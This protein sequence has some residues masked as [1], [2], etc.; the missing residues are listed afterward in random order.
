MICRRNPSTRS[1]PSPV[2]TCIQANLRHGKTASASFAQIMMELDIDVALVQKPYAFFDKLIPGVPIVADVPEGFEALHRLDTEH[3]YGAALLTKKKLRATLCRDA[4]NNHVACATIPMGPA[5]VTFASVYI[6]PTAA[7]IE[8]VLSAPLQA[9]DRL[10][11]SVLGIDANARNPLWGSCRADAKGRELENLLL[12]S[13][14]VLANAALDDLSFRPSGTSFI[15]VTLHGCDVELLGWKYLDMPSL[16]DHPL[17][18]FQCRTAQIAARLNPT[19]QER[20]STFRSVKLPPPPA[21][22]RL[23]FSRQIEQA[24]EAHPP[25]LADAEEIDEA[26][27]IMT[28]AVQSAAI[29]SKLTNSSRHVPEQSKKMPWWNED[30]LDLRNRMWRASATWNLRKTEENRLRHIGLRSDYRRAIRAA[31]S[32]AFKQF[33]TEIG[34]DLPA[35]IKAIKLAHG[36][37]AALPARI[38]VGGEKIADQI[39]ILKACAAHFFPAD[40]PGT[41]ENRAIAAKAKE[42]LASANGG[43]PPVL[44]GEVGNA[45]ASL[46]TSSAPGPD[47]VSTALIQ[48]GPPGLVVRMGNIYD[49]CLKTGYFPKAWRH[50]RVS[51]IPKPGKP[52]YSSLSSFR[53]ISVVNAFSKGL[54]KIILTR[55]QWLAEEGN[56]FSDHQHGFRPG[57]STESAAHDLVHFIE[58][59]K[60]DNKT[61]AVAFLDIK[62]AFDSAWRPAII[63]ALANKGCPGYLLKIVDAFLAARTATISSSGHHL[64]TKIGTGCPQGSVLSPFLWNVLI[65]EVLR[66]RLHFPFKLVAYA[67]DLTAAVAHRD[68][69]VAAARLQLICRAIMKWAAGVKLAINAAKTTF[70]LFSRR[71]WRKIE[72]IR[73]VLAGIA[74]CPSKLASFL[75][76]TLDWRLSWRPHIERKTLA[77]KQ[78]GMMVKRHI[79]RNWG[80]TAQRIRTVYQA[81]VEPT[82]VYC[83]SVWSAAVDHTPS[84]IHLRRIQRAFGLYISRAFSSTSTEAVLNLAGFLPVDLRIK[85]LSARRYL[86]MANA[87][88]F[89]PRTVSSI[90]TLLAGLEKT[91]RADAAFHSSAAPPWTDA[92]ARPVFLPRDVPVPMFST[93]N[94]SARVYTDGSVTGGRA[95]Y[96]VVICDDRGIFATCKGRLDDHCSVLQAEGAAIREALSFLATAGGR[97][98]SVDILTDSRAAIA[99]CCTS[100]KVSPLFDDI[101]HRINESQRSI[102]FYWLAGH[103]GHPGNELADSLAKEGAKTLSSRT[104]R[105]ERPHSMLKGELRSR[106]ANMWDQEWR[107]CS[108]GAVTRLFLP[109]TTIPP[110]LVSFNISRPLAQLLTGHSYLRAHLFR[111]GLAD[112]AVCPCGAEDETVPHLIFSCPSHSAERAT[113]VRAA[114]DEGETWPFGLSRF[115]DSSALLHALERFARSCGRLVRPSESIQPAA[116]T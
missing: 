8:S 46:K 106:A 75:G 31:K 113:L 64:D 7:N 6:R 69:R 96:G 58:T 47:G 35:T 82:V 15:D 36:G 100:P 22:D 27:R 52:D 76:L 51:V 95:G 114:L 53:P 91:E 87:A 74:L 30:L 49:A 63:A 43:H 9:I 109:S 11:L 104:D 80:L 54:E 12:G 105:M 16:S 23:L 71:H 115:C 81:V 116:P 97:F 41:N 77:A 55:L 72:D 60:A 79:G 39:E 4:S 45:L 2:L 48:I 94:D 111:T 90:S 29:A 65:D 88:P 26:V 13:P 44:P 101:R 62:S 42:S 89:S 107:S 33:A 61:V 93:S 112:S 110:A 59:S 37:G 98:E 92:A 70:S 14:L 78:L 86:A 56:W 34:S 32:T 84:R 99:G 102:R 66:L 50:A 24:L 73:L 5:L 21:I 83:C 57:R 68:P 67:D 38:D 10:N 17:I 85:E 3:H 103:L 1:N 108:K 18:V 40:P 19:G 25:A 28:A 20:Q